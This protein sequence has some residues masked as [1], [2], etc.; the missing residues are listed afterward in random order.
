MY[1]IPNKVCG[2]VCEEKGVV[3][4]GDLCTVVISLSH[5]VSL[6]PTSST[7]SSYIDGPLPWG[8][9]STVCDFI[10]FRSYSSVTR[11]P[12]T[13]LQSELAESSQTPD[14]EEWLKGT[15]FRRI[16]GRDVTF[17]VFT[18]YSSTTCSVT[19]SGLSLGTST[20]HQQSIRRP[21][22]RTETQFGNKVY[23]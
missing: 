19:G 9:S 6:L 23:S 22:V 10:F 15:H 13:T 4:T 7:S 17:T 2:C 3:K 16:R 14:E 21:V 5:I 11:S 8:F 20:Y 1:I 12:S 18:R